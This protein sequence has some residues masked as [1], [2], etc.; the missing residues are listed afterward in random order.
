[1]FYQTSDLNFRL[2]LVRATFK[3]FELW[4]HLIKVNNKNI[5]NLIAYDISYL[6]LRTFY[7]VI[8]Y[9]CFKYKEKG[10]QNLKTI[11]VLNPT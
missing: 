5:K 1:M 7:S 8:I 2:T 4:N 3:I 10:P 9:L 11:F 6:L